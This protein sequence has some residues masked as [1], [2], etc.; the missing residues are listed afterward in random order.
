MSLSMLFR[1]LASW[2]CLFC[3]EGRSRK[4]RS[5]ATGGAW[6]GEWG[7][8]FKVPAGVATSYAVCALAKALCHLGLAGSLV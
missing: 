1:M 4:G 6:E 3:Y 7:W 8:G 2:L 5:G